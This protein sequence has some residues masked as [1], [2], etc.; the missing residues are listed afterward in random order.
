MPKRHQCPRCASTMTERA[1]ADSED[2]IYAKWVMCPCGF[3]TRNPS[4]LAELQ[5][6]DHP[7]AFA[8]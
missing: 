5:R 2:R 6:A 3:D 8:N 4:D 7:V 1:L